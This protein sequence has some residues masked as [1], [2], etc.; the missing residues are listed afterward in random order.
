QIIPALLANEIQIAYGAGEVKAPVD[1]G[2]LVALVTTGPQRW[3]LFPNIPTM[4][5]AGYPT[6][7]SA[8]WIGTVAPPDAP[9]DAVAK[10]N[11]SFNAA[12]KTPEVVARMKGFGMVGLG[13]T[14]EQMTQRIKDEFGV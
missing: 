14:P 4:V 2:R 1:S 12:L 9:A 13:S 6:H 11:A 3:D 10:I 8:F 7:I 5:E